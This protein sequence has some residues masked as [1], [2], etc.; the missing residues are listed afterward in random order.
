M[1]FTEDQ[2]EQAYIELLT[3]LGYEHRLGGEIEIDERGSYQEV[4]LLD[5][6]RNSIYKINKDMPSDAKEEAIKKIR[7]LSNPTLI[8]A[9]EEF[10]KMI[11]DGIDIPYKDKE[12]NDRFGKIYIFDFKNLENN[13]FQAVNQFTIIQKTNRR[14]DIILFVNGI[15][16][17]VIEL[18]SM[19]NEE[20]GI[21]EAYNQIQ[22][23]KDEISD[24]FKYNSFI[25]LSDGI[26]AKAGTIS[27]NFERFMSFRSVDGE[28]I[29]PKDEMMMETLTH[30]MLT[31][32]RLLELTKDYI[33]FMKTKTDSVKILAQ[34][35]QFFA[36]KK[37]LEKTKRA[38]E[39][40]GR[41]G[42]VWHTQ[43]SGKSLTMTFYTGQ[44][45]KKFNNPTIVV[46][47]DRNDLDNQ[48]HGTFSK[49]SSYLVEDPKQAEDK[50]E[51]RKYKYPP[52]G[53]E[54]ALDTVLRQAKL[55]CEEMVA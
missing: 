12:G 48:L 46:V 32:E 17:V 47:T 29:R 20:V 6:L 37:A 52:K 50:D 42:V 34:Y 14:P 45:M 23:Y 36:V 19:I 51:L 22:R 11:T 28:E 16:M 41:I 30:G 53:Q 35:H 7:H 15:P 38:K 3:D 5:E 26:N 10:H 4:L 25:V 44:L 55:M 8:K 27:S 49:C 2:L 13:I 43:G 9:N 21:T 40:Q 1:N 18:K 24:L 54:K 39:S 31:K 33:L